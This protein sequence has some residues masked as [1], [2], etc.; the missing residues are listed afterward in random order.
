MFHFV[1]LAAVDLA[2]ESLLK[3]V[4]SH[5]KELQ[6]AGNT[7][8]REGTPVRLIAV[9]GF[10]AEEAQSG[11]RVSLVLADELIVNG[12]VLARAGDVASG[13]V[14]QVIRGEAANDA[15]NVMLEGVTLR[16]GA[17][18]VPL[19]SSQARGNAGPLQR[20]ELPES[21]KSE[22]T[23]FVAKDVEFPNDQ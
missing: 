5:K 10:T 21:G 1:G 9:H 6:S 8:V 23:L 11:G 13:Q 15:I 17:L 3:K 4:T 7:V 16:A 12:R 19:R 18:Y 20:R 22:L 2:Q 14:G